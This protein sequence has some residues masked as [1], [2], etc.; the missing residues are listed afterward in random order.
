VIV[1]E[2]QREWRREQREKKLSRTAPSARAVI[3]SLR[4]FEA[5]VPKLMQSDRVGRLSP[6][7]RRVVARL[8]V[9]CADALQKGAARL[10]RRHAVEP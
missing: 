4:A 10:E 6:G 8:L 9:Q 1:S 2:R 3:D 5:L 7:A